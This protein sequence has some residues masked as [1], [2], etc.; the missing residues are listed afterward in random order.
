MVSHIKRAKGELLEEASSSAS[1]SMQAKTQ[2]KFKI[3]VLKRA[4][5]LSQAFL[6]ALQ[7]DNMCEAFSTAGEKSKPTSVAFDGMEETYDT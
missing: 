2:N 7:G 5:E 1:G 4:S 6:A 3:T